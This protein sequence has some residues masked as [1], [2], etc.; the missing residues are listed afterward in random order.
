M[1]RT[2]GFFGSF[3]C[4]L[5]FR[6]VTELILFSAHFWGFL[7]SFGHF[8]LLEGGS[9]R[10]VRASEGGR[11][12]SGSV[13][14]GSGIRQPGSGRRWRGEIRWSLGAAW[15]DTWA[16]YSFRSSSNS[17]ELW[18]ASRTVFSD[19]K[20]VLEGVARRLFSSSG[21]GGPT[22]LGSI[23]SGGGRSGFR[24]H[25]EFPTRVYRVEKRKL[26]RILGKWLENKGKFRR[27]Q[28]NRVFA[29]IG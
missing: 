13:R 10:R 3:S 20:G 26:G 2:G 16:R 14:R 8:F 12:R 29:K 15:A 9:R 28:W 6:Q 27:S 22:G 4:R 7:G 18:Q 5:L 25:K 17:S 21:G 24:R 11:P 23:D 19:V 1:G